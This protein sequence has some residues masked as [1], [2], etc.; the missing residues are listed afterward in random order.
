MAASMIGTMEPYDESGEPF[1]SYLERFDLYVAANDIPDD[2]KK[3]VFLSII[4]AK[5]YQLLRSLCSPDLPSAKSFT[6][7]TKLLKDHLAPAPLEIAETYR[8]HQRSQQPN[9]S[10]HDYVAQLKLLSEHC[11][12]PA[13]CRNRILRDRLVCGLRSD[14]VRKKLLSEKD[15]TL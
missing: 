14:A 1:A 13:I 2:R 8:F 15:L 4:G 5:T 7:C 10:I 9:E 12:F 6:G 3:A 11:N